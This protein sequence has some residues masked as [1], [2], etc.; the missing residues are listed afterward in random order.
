MADQQIQRAWQ[1]DRHRFAGLQAK[2]GQVC[3][4]AFGLGVQLGIGQ[5][6]P[7]LYGGRRV[8][9]RLGLGFE[10]GVNGLLPGV[11]AIGLVEREQHLFSLGGRQD[12]QAVEPRIRGLFQRCDQAFDGGLHVVAQARRTDLRT[13]LHG[14]GEVIGEVV[15]RDNQRVVGALLGAEGFDA[16]P[17]QARVGRDRLGRAGAVAIIQQGAE[18]RRR[19][20]HSAAA[21][22]Q[23]QGRVFVTEQGAE[24][25]MGGLDPV[26]HALRAHADPQRQGV[27]EHAQRPAHVFRSLHAPQH[28]RAKHYIFTPRHTAQHLSPGEVDHARGADS[29][30]SRLCSQATAQ[31][32]WQWTLDFFDGAAVAQHILLAK[33]QGRLVDIAK[34]LAEKRF[35][36]LALTGLP[37]ARDVVAVR[38]GSL[39]L[40][41]LPHQVRL[42]FMLDHGE[43][44]MVEGHVVKKQHRDPALVQRVFGEH[45]QQQRR[46]ADVKPMMTW[47]ETRLQLRHGIAVDNLGADVLQAQARM[48][49]HHLH[50][51]IQAFADDGG[52]QDVVTIDHA[53]QRVGKIRQAFTGGDAEL[54][55]QDVGIALAGGQVVIK[56]PFLQR[57]QRINVLHVGRTARHRGDN[58]LDGRLIQAHQGQHRRRDARAAERYAVARDLDVA[59]LAGV[60]LPGLDQLDQRRF[61]LTQ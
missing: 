14:Q 22:G 55:L 59:G 10:Q 5:G 53:L 60:V 50:R 31:F 2:A 44:R 21:L 45:Q 1:Q 30:Q 32:R 11:L 7:G 6:L 47:V 17:G 41:G 13:R 20:R 15:D 57:R 4:Q 12:Q 8:G 42:H 37:S 58:A 19:R 29:D 36:G 25:R 33:G 16:A 9:A 27:D 52:A 28:H 46:L 34:H 38:H 3:G 56:N 49:P 40:L 26:A 39:Q 54:C 35:V 61:V 24:P 23:C 18:Q 43:R 51:F 48:A